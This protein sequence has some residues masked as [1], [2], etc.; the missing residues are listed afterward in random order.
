MML[1]LTFASVPAF[2]GTP[3]GLEVFFP[4]VAAFPLL[5]AVIVLLYSLLLLISSLT[6][7]PCV[8]VVACVPAIAGVPGVVGISAVAF[9]SL[10]LM[11]FPLLLTFLLSL[12]SQLLLA[13]FLLQAS[14]ADPGVPIYVCLYLLDCKMRHIRLSDYWMDIGMLFIL[15]L[16]YENIE[17][18]TCE[19]E[20]LRAFGQSVRLSDIGRT[21]N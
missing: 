5:L 11:A 14:P 8:S 2:S 4:V 9:V 13:S 1:L 18:R 15:Q 6:T 19:F 20:K 17:H 7:V 12:A 10:L 16:Y 3:S 21:K